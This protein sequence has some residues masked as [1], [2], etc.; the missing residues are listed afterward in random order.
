M[1]IGGYHEKWHMAFDMAV[2][3]SFPDENEENTITTI[4]SRSLNIN[5]FEEWLLSSSHPT[6]TINHGMILYATDSRMSSMTHLFNQI[7][8]EY[9]L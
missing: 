5:S 8:E 3:Q 7:R 9:R 1:A 2:I 4:S 6:V